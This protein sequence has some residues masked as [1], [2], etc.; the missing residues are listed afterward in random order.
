[1]GE[2]RFTSEVRNVNNAHFRA[3]SP[4]SCSKPLFAAA[5]RVVLS[6]EVVAPGCLLDSRQHLDL[7]SSAI[8]T[9]I[10]TSIS[11]TR[12][13]DTRAFLFQSFDPYHG[14]R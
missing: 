3:R 9:C 11:S 2:K 12:F 10:S 13:R 8:L 5:V 7:A 6:R 1:M 4:G 14:T